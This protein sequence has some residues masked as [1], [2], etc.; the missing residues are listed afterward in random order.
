MKR[1]NALFFGE[2]PNTII[3]GVSLSNQRILS[4]LRDIYNVDVIS[5]NTS[6]NYTSFFRQLYRHISILLKIIKRNNVN[7]E[8]FYLTCPLSTFSQSK[9]I[10]LVLIFK[11]LNPKACVVSHL[12][13]SDLIEFCTNKFNSYLLKTFFLLIDELVVLSEHNIRC[14]NDLGFNV[15][16]HVIYNTVTGEVPYDYTYSRSKKSG[17]VCLNNYIETKGYRDLFNAINAKKLS[18]FYDFN[19]FGSISDFQLYEHLKSQNLDNVTVET[20][21]KSRKKFSVIANSKFLIMPSLNEGMPL[22]ILEALSVG[23]PVICFDVGCISDYLGKDYPGLVKSVSHFDF[24]DKI[25]EL[26]SLSSDDYG[27]LSSYSHQLYWSSFSN[28]IIN[29]YTKNYFIGLHYE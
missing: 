4:V 23:T 18:V 22:V 11:F 20:S 28:D 19:F 24:V 21:I 27:E 8:L 10:L 13:R 26:M 7:Y 29:N 2:L 16:A 6:F 15:N 12:H 25:N 9:F 3:H 17:V 14:L 5:D 1:R